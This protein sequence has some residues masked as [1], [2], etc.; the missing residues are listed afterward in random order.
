[1]MSSSAVEADVREIGQW[2]D[3]GTVSEAERWLDVVDPATGST[4]AH[5]G[6]ASP[7]QVDQAVRS[8]ATAQPA[9]GATSLARRARVLFA[10]RGL[11]DGH[12][13]VLADLISLEHGKV[14]ADADGEVARALDAIEFAC[15]APHLLRGAATTQ[16]ATGIDL[17]ELRQPLGVVAGITPF[18]FPAMVPAWMHP[19]AIATGNAFVLKPSEHAPSASLLIAQLWRDAGLPDGVFNVVNGDRATAEALVAHPEVAAVSFVGSTPVARAVHERARTDGKRVQALGGAKNHLVVLPD[20]DLDQAADAAVSAGY[21]SAGQRCMAISVVV[22]V[23]GTGDAL[24]ERIRSRAE[25]VRIGAFTDLDAEM[26]PVISAAARARIDGL[27]ATG[28]QEGARL[29]LDGRDPQVAGHAAGF[30]VGPTL[31]DD[32]VGD[33]TIYRE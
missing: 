21:G 7:E 1:M 20:A 32:V 24:V 8:A 11:V 14:R 31:F 17:R 16:A 29:V 12:R 13:D 9:W 10:F 30:W 4:V 5:V 2:I 15:G 25:A 23:G 33:H 22:A 28:V 6:V 18:N 27:I 19:L 3:G 26:G